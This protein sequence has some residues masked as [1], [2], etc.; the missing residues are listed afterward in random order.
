M[1]TNAMQ[2]NNSGK[3]GSATCVCGAD[4]PIM[5]GQK[6]SFT[7]V[8]CSRCEMVYVNPQPTAEELLVYYSKEYWGSHQKNLGLCSI[9]ERLED[10]N[11]RRYFESIFRWLTKRVKLEEGMR[12]LEVGCSHGMFCE[13]AIKEGLEVVGV[14]MD[15]EIAAATEKRIGAKVFA[16]GLS[17]Q[18][19][20][21]AEFDVV[22]MFDVLE[23]FTNPVEELSRI[24]KL[25]KPGGWL[26]LSTP[27]RDSFTAQSDVLSWGENKP[28]EH[29]FLFAY[30]DIEKLLEKYNLFVFDA[31]GIYSDRMYI[32]A[33]CGCKPERKY[34]KPNLLFAMCKYAAKNLERSIRYSLKKRA[35]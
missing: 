29:L 32:L 21:E 31:K 8:Q 11:E 15:A 12:L 26:Y 19:F 5:L 3:R 16:G 23:H 17:T 34:H 27:C 25:L 35:S 1:A 6:N 33:R 22:V 28:P 9:E 4:E 24:Q 13:L 2:N 7:V 14:E 18:D 20:T 30:D 10:P